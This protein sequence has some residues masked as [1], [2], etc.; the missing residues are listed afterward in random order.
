MDEIKN[1]EIPANTVSQSLSDDNMRQDN[2]WSQAVFLNGIIVKM[3][4][5]SSI[6]DSLSIIAK[7]PLNVR[8]TWK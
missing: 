3:S 2:D 7:S 5:D 6:E 4:Y 8:G 1:K